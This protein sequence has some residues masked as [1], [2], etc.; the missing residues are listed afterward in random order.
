MLQ[1]KLDR[2][3]VPYVYETPLFHLEHTDG[4]EMRVV[5]LYLIKLYRCVS[6]WQ[7]TKRFL[8]SCICYYSVVIIIAIITELTGFSAFTLLFP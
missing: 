1:L 4:R 3:V 5:S 2:E 6:D 7:E 8:R